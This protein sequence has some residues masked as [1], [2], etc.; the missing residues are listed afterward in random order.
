MRRVLPFTALLLAGCLSAAPEGIA[1]AEAADT[2]VKLD[3]EHRPLPDLPL[4]NDLATRYDATSATGRRLN[5]SMIAPT[6]MEERVRTLLDGQDGW[7]VFA[8]ISIPFTGPIDV[9]S[10]LAGHR[11]A[12]FD[13]ADDVVYLVN[14]TPDSP[15]FGEAT[16]LDIGNGSFPMVLE[17][18]DAYW[19]NDPRGANLTMYFEEVNEDVD[20]DGVLDPGEDTDLDG[21]LDLP[22]YFPGVATPAADDLIARADATMTF[23]E[24]E[25]NTLIVRPMEPLLER[26]TYAV[27]VTR[28]LKDAAGN[29]VGSPYPFVNHAAQTTALLPLLD[30]LPAGLDV[31]DIGFAFSFTTQTIGSAWVAVRDGLYG[32]G[33]QGHLGAEYP[34]D[35]H[36]LAPLVDPTQVGSATQVHILRG[37]DFKPVFQSLA[38]QLL[39]LDADSE[40]GRV[41]LEGL[42][43]VDYIVMGTYRSPQLFPRVDADGAPLNNN[44]QSWP[45]D[46]DRVPAPAR[47]ED[48]WFTLVVPRK[49]VSARGEGKPAPTVI[50]GHGYGSSRFEAISFAGHF[51]RQGLA[52]ISIDCVSHGLGVGD[53]ERE[54]AE[55]V[56]GGYGLGPFVGALFSDRALDQNGDGRVDSGAD[57]WTG[58]L[59]HTRDV[60]RQSALD[61]LQLVRILRAFDG[62]KRS[63]F[64][65]NGDGAKDL[66]GDF[67]G[68]GNIDIGG[69]ATLGMTGGSLGGIMAAVVGAIEPELDTIAP[70]SAGGGLGDTGA[71][72]TLGGVRAA[73][74]LR[75][76]GPLFIGDAVDG[77]LNVRTVIPDLNDD[78][79]F[80]LGA[81][82]GV[83]PGQIF[84]VENGANGERGCGR[85]Q[86]DG[87]V[88]AAV[89]SDLH[90]PIRLTLY[91]EADLVTGDDCVIAGGATPIA[92]L[93]TFGEEITFQAGTFAAGSPLV[94]L[95]EG[96]G[97]E[98][99]TPDLR[100]FL[101][102][103]QLVLD[104]ADPA[105]F[106]K[107]LQ[108][109]P[110]KFPGKGDQTGTHALIVTSV[111]DMVVPAAGGASI[112][113]AAGFIDYKS[114]DPRWGKSQH[115]VLVD[116]YTLEGVHNLGRFRDPA[117]NGVHMDIEDFGHGEDLWT[118]L[119]PRLDP[120]FRAYGPDSLGG[121]SGS[122]FP[123]PT[124]EGQH[125]FAFPGA[126][127]D[128]L[129]ARCAAAC[130]AGQDCGC[131]T[132]TTF[133]VGSF[134]FGMMGE[135]IES[136]GM[137]LNPDLCHSRRD[138]P[139]VPPP[140]GPRD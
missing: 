115:Q 117:G 93:E 11:D 31:S 23:Y 136:G 52:T 102:L 122:I 65:T 42:D 110:L 133:D 81:M 57:F 107:H 10:I 72:T 34:P 51:A 94:S 104:G 16:A 111:G 48:V 83:L 19:A 17:N 46:L 5:A 131:A 73:V 108:R 103:G 75:V 56:L 130:P 127:I 69:D 62:Q 120:P 2:T 88:R 39:G 90:D 95:Q 40:E 134:M 22:N 54:L 101:G 70:I 71:R 27:I 129:R 79:T 125:G 32:H 3:F 1:P 112:G 33:V 26:T 139:G 63:R 41:L 12:T 116:T 20:G 50:L 44:L 106:A 37:E 121:I 13:L 61:Y 118:G 78:S 6:K 105:V 138:C 99:G 135:W 49:E 114:I 140:P 109:L 24:R 68:D 126:Q 28:R 74:V 29:P 123:Y 82:A 60:V 45:Q 66:A 14:V 98:R 53:E 30:V 7:G 55:L 89:A 15:E 119:I 59:F 67:D 128:T 100:R 58:Y 35:L 8:P 86:A 91:A 84:L 36:S 38:S 113:R 47:S 77:A 25:T 96:L 4:P 132:A 137:T 97:L 92:T 124:P 64:D 76:M 21:V 43:Y 9:G 80:P 87:R 18:R 85:V